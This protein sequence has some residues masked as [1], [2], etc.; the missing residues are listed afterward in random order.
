MATARRRLEEVS[1]HFSD[2]SE[3]ADIDVEAV[4][5]QLHLGEKIALLSGI[6]DLTLMS[7]LQLNI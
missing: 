7:G 3:M 4:L 1:K 2:S 6:L 5:E